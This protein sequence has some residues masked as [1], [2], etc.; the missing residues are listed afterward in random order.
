MI[1]IQSLFV[2]LISADASA[3]VMST[4]VR[5]QAG[6]LPQGR[7]MVSMVSVQSSIDQMFNRNGGKETLSQNFNQK[8]TFQKI[9]TEEPV[10]GNQL[11]GLFMSNGLSLADSAG[12]VSGS[13]TGTVSGK[14]P[15]LGYGI[16]DD[17]GIF[18]ALPII[19]FKINAHYQFQQS[20]KTVGFLKQLKNTDQASIAKEFDTALNTSLENKL[21]KNNYDWNSA[22]NKNYFGDMQINLVK[23]LVNSPDFKSQVQPFVILPTSSDQDLR[24]LYGL[25]AGEGRF[26]MGAKYA[27][28]KQVF[29]FLQLNAGVSATY[30]FPSEQGRRLPKDQI[31]QLNELMDSHVWVTGGMSYHSQVQIRYPFPKWVGLNLGVD[32]QQRFRDSLSGN[33]QDSFAYRN[34]EAKTGSSLLTSY[35]SIDLNSIQ[36]FLSGGFLFPAIAELGVGLPIV[37]VNAIAEPVVQ[38]QGTMFF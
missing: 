14:V 33:E 19:E 9:T 15:V 28:Q 18:F 17:L 35:A 29:N 16:K 25:R 21:F 30:L 7:F 26:G 27:A 24:D 37:G 38:L 8:I 22:L 20:S 5:E 32:W 3:Q 2:F 31:D 12:E 11:A 34:A 4:F 6:S 1:L 10:R 13:V 23:I 36:S